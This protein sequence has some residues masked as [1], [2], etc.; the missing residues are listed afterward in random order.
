MRLT[1]EIILALAACSGWI[2]FWYQRRLAVKAV[3]AA[4]EST[5]L[6]EKCFAQLKAVDVYLLKR[7][8]WML[9]TAAALGVILVF[10]I[11][12]RKSETAN[13]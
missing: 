13:E 1:L 8:K 10:A 4:K 2:F 7:K 3:A 6:V 9:L 5:A 12:R 11:V